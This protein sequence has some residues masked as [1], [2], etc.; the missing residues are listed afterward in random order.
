MR[1]QEVLDCLEWGTKNALA[2]GAACRTQAAPLFQIGQPDR[3]D[4]ELKRHSII[5]TG[6]ADA[7]AP[8][9]IEELKEGL[10]KKGAKR[11][12]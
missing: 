11:V 3:N 9:R 7:K 5:R 10:R 4:A 8:F 1:I 12:A 6:D 2:I